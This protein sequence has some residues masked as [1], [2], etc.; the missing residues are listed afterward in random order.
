LQLSYGLTQQEA[1][2][3]LRVAAG[4]S[5]ETIAEQLDLSIHTV[6]THLKR[7]YDKVGVQGQT[8]LAARLMAGPVGWLARADTTHRAR[9]VQ[10]MP[11][12]DVV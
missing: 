2:V 10:P 6:R 1:N 3:A 9:A 11:L 7:T 5:P 4:K 12:L 8:E